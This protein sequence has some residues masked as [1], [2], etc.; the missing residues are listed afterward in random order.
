MESSNLRFPEDFPTDYQNLPTVSFVIPNMVRDMHD[1]SPPES[2]QSG[3]TWLRKNLDP[4]YQ[5]AKTHNS[6]LILTFDEDA[7]ARYPGGLTDPAS[8]N[9]R[10]ANRIPTIF[11][12][13]RIQHGDFN[14]GK[15]VNHV[16]I[17]RTLESMYRL[18]RAGKQP[19]Y[20]DR[21]GIGD[22]LVLVDVFE[23]ANR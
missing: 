9:P 21:A 16:T 8:P 15:G 11:A 1:G 17:L 19:R 20:A 18:K 6:L 22:D 12:G 10:V 23:K 4:Y 13:A 2:I 5:W 7:H 3:D 14:E